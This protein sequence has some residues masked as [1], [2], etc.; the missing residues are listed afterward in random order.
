MRKKIDQFNMVI[1]GTGGQG[2]ITLLQILAEAAKIEGYDVKTSELHGLSQRGGSVEVHI[3]F[4][5]KVFSPLVSQGRAD[6]IGGLEM[7]ESLK[8]ASY[9][10]SQTVFLVNKFKI[11]IP[12]QKS[13]SEDE[14]FKSLKKISKKV[15]VIPGTEITKK[16]LGNG[17]VA[18]VFMVSLAVFKNL[19]PLNENSII[20]AIKKI[21]SHKYLDL[22]LKT[23]KL[24]KKYAK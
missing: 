6:L 17:V 24:A 7:Q 14:I 12:L 11:P 10:N 19:I 3:R 4:G 13:L 20:K 23:V 2:L 15:S 8:S 1:T 16:E 22:N 18:G 9:A 5:K 21:V